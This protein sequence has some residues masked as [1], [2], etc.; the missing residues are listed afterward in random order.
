MR[1]ACKYVEE[2]LAVKVLI[3]GIWPSRVRYAGVSATCEV[4]RSDANLT[5]AIF[6]MYNIPCRPFKNRRSSQIYECLVTVSALGKL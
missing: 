6:E 4:V 5:C 1:E 3:P 2:K